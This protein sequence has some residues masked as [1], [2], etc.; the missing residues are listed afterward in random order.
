MRRRS[1]AIANAHAGESGEFRQFLGDW[2]DQTAPDWK[3]GSM[4]MAMIGPHLPVLQLKV[5]IDLIAAIA[6]ALVR[7]A[8]F[9]SCYQL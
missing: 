7:L 5:I 6:A 2:R 9:V 1:P 3:S 4:F 8:L